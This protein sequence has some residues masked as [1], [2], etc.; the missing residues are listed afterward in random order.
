VVSATGQAIFA[1]VAKDAATKVLKG[2]GRSFGGVKSAGE[3]ALGALKVAA[4]AAAA[5]IAAMG[6]AAVNAAV[7]DERDT[8]RLNAALRARGILTDDLKAKIDAQVMSMAALGFTDDDVRAGIETGSRF[9]KKQADL[10]KVNSV[11]ADIAAVSGKSLSDVVLAIGRGANGSTRGLTTLGIKVKSGAKL[12]DILTKAT[13]KYGGAASEIANTTAGKFA[14]AQIGLNEAFEKMGYE[15]L[16]IVNDAL[17]FFSTTVLPAVQDALKLV[18]PA[19]GKIVDA[20]A[21][22]AEAVGELAKTLWDDGK[23]PLAVALTAIGIAF[24]VAA[25]FAKGFF[26][27]LTNIVKIVTTLVELLGVLGE[28]LRNSPNIIGSSVRIPGANYNGGGTMA[29][30]NGA[31]IRFDIGTDKQDKLVGGTLARNAGKSRVK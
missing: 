26:R 16:P 12:Q 2:V 10:L 11:A 28:S 9:F 22:L 31:D 17:D 5:A 30:P 23:G 7:Q 13:E 19:F 20:I 1:I 14:K 15:F 6:I 8:A 27:T 21:P 24:D 29:N 18:R 4:V 25:G 3:K